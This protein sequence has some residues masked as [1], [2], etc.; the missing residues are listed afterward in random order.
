ML[1]EWNYCAKKYTVEKAD[2]TFILY[3]AHFTKDPLINHKLLIKLDT[4]IMIK[5]ES[6]NSLWVITGPLYQHPLKNMI[7]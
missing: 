5:C 3:R 1:R 4:Q 2:G 6:N 7:G